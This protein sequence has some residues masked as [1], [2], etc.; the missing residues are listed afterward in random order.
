MAVWQYGKTY[1]DRIAVCMVCKN[2]ACIGTKISRFNV[3]SANKAFRQELGEQVLIARTVDSRKV[4]EM[5]NILVDSSSTLMLS[6]HGA[7]ELEALRR[8]TSD[9]SENIDS[10]TFDRLCERNLIEVCPK[11]ELGDGTFDYGVT[12]EGWRF[13]ANSLREQLI[14]KR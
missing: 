3:K 4:I 10:E 14:Y 2:K 7:Q 11:T 6:E 1:I 8:L 12:H 13:I 5:I 9:E